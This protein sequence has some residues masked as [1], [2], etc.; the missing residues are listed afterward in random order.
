MK[1]CFKNIF[2]PVV[3][4]FGLCGAMLPAMA[5]VAVD[6]AVGEIRKIDKEAGKVTIKHGE[7]K[8]LDMPPMTMV[9]QLKEPALI[10]KFKVGDKVQFRVIKE[11]RAYLLT[12]IL[13]QE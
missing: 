2:R 4:A 1:L 6:Y 9:F 7:I 12:E 11:G 3:L 8:T 10:E 13:P 5:Q